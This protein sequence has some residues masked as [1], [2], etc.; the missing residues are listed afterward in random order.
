[1]QRLN[2]QLSRHTKTTRPNQQVVWLVGFVALILIFLTWRLSAIWFTRDTL[3]AASPDSTILAIEL[4]LSPKTTPIIAKMFG[5]VTLISNRSLSLHDLTHIT[6]GEVAIFVTKD[7][8]RAVAIRGNEAS[9]PKEL[10]TSYGITS[11]IV[12]PGV[13]LFSETLLSV[14]G[15]N[16]RVSFPFFPSSSLW[17]GRVE[18]PDLGVSGTLTKNSGELLLS[19]KTPKS[20][21]I[22]T[23]KL[24]AGV[25]SM[26]LPDSGEQN[27]PPVS[28]YSMNQTSQML[29]LLR[30][31]HRIFMQKDELGELQIL[32]SIPNSGWEQNDLTVALQKM[33]SYLSPK[34]QEKILADGTSTKEILIEPDIV[35]VEEISIAGHMMLRTNGNGGLALYGGFINGETIVSTGEAIVTSFLNPRGE[36][37][38]GNLAQLSPVDL[39]GEVQIASYNPQI[40]SLLGLF[41]GISAIS[42]ESKKYSTEVH[43]CST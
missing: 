35:T 5:N 8:S 36:D 1:M 32:V 7:G 39:L 6:N 21:K 37:C 19:L 2:I 18:L 4:F 29:D 31:E 12:R 15:I 23:K 17:L 20:K 38:S 13:V 24:P 34:I 16:S 43:I 9:L 10:L 42:F 30:K 11:Q 25:L 22:N 41:N 14:S 40:S 27:A 3:L 33:G 26:L 28:T